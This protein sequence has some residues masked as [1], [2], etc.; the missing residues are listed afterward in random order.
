[1]RGLRSPVASSLL[2]LCAVGYLHSTQGIRNW[3][4]ITSPSLHR[5]SSSNSR[6]GFFGLS[7][8]VSSFPRGGADVATADDDENKEVEEEVL[9]LP[10]LLDTELILNDH[11]SIFLLPS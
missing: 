5:T 9:Y 4:E 7:K 6:T 10:G 11:V 8:T 2:L 3:A 1:M